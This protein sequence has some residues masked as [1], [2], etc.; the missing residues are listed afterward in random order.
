MD[1]GEDEP[2]YAVGQDD[3]L[4]IYYESQKSRLPEK[5]TVE[6]QL[7]GLKREPANVTIKGLIN[8]TNR[9]AGQVSL[10]I[11]EKWSNKVI[12]T[13]ALILGRITES[14]P[15]TCTNFN[16][17]VDIKNTELADPEFLTRSKIDVL[18]EAD[19]YGEILLEGLKKG[20]PT[21][22]K[23]KLGWILSGPIA[24]SAS[25]TST[26][27]KSTSQLDQQ[28]STFWEQE[29]IEKKPFL[30]HEQEMAEKQYITNVQRI[31]DGRYKVK[32]P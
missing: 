25:T 4:N 18:L 6:A 16:V 22:Q 5:D 31:K 27:I 10:N 24:R 11:R 20:M 21:A 9:R 14:L 28:L 15:S 12:H 2:N 1:T 23:T 29:E 30:S 13:T 32:M 26:S 17:N 8:A 7:L 3:P 19:A